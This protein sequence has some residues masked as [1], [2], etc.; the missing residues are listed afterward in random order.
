MAGEIVFTV[1]SPGE[2]STWLAPTVAAL[3]QLDTGVHVSV[4]ILPCLYASG[5]EAE[6][7]R[8]MPG[9][10]SV[11]TPGESWRY[12]LRGRL[13]AGWKPRGRGAVV[14]LG[15]EMLL[16]ARL[17]RRLG[18]PAAA[19]TQGHVVSSRDFARFFVPREG[20]RAPPRHCQGRS[21]GAGGGGGRPHGG[22][23]A[24]GPGPRGTGG[25]GLAPGT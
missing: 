12:I 23:G 4:H 18:Y 24:S 16:A 9:V 8:G 19:Y 3:R 25:L 21:G 17:A 10:D 2:V 5:T 15:G 20:R 7:I 6:V 14:F 11:V 1:N 13:P 22:R